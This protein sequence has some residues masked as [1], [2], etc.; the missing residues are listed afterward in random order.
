MPPRTESEQL[1]ASIWSDLLNVKQVGIH[2]NF[3]D[4]GGEPLLA[5]ELLA[6]LSER[7]DV[8]LPDSRAP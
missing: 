5:I 4:L 3:F 7:F 8:E 6:R 2:D 1:L